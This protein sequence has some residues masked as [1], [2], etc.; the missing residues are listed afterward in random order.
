MHGVS[1]IIVAVLLA[2]IAAVT[3]VAAYT[4]AAPQINLSFDVTESQAVRAALETCNDKI[5]ET[6]RTGSG[7]TCVIPASRGVVT[8]QNDGLYYQ[9]SSSGRLCDPTDWA[10]I[11]PDKHIE[12]ACQVTSENASIYNLRWRYPKQLEINATELSG[13]LRHDVY[14]TPIEFSN[15]TFRTVSVYV[16]LVSY[17]G[18]GGQHVEFSRKDVTPDNVT[19]NVR[20]Y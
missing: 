1:T 20:I 6:A 16:Y 11:N 19:L 18:A 14:V 8:A 4:W 2:A 15:T 12:L 13:E 9:L 7:N 10:L 17:P 3:A 5:I